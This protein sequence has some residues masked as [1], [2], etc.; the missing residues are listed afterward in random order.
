MCVVEVTEPDL[1]SFISSI[2]FE[3]I[4]PPTKIQKYLPHTFS[5]FSIFI[6]DGTNFYY[7]PFTCHSLSLICQNYN[8]STSGRLAKSSTSLQTSSISST[9]YI[10]FLYTLSHFK[11]S[12]T[13]FT[14]IFFQKKNYS[15][16][17]FI[18]SRAS[19]TT[20]HKS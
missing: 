6:H 16:S 7:L 10:N 9:V 11:K 20:T 8:S 1:K 19:I 18:S 17:V 13:L 3:V 14:L 5:Y 4:L 2:K 12:F 15:F